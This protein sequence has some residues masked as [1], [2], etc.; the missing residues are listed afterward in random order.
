MRGLNLQ[1]VR[2]PGQENWRIFCAIE[3]PDNARERVIEHIGR[4][5]ESVRHAHASWSRPENIHLTLKFLGRLPKSGVGNLSQAA[6][7]SVEGFSIFKIHLEEAG[8]FPS[9]GAPRVLWIGVKDESGKL[10]ELQARLEDECARAGI[11][12]EKR[13][14][15]PHFTL[16]RLRES[17]GARNLASAHKQMRFQPFKLTV[18]E[19]L[20]IRSELNSDGSKYTLI[21]Q[22]PLGG[23]LSQI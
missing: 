12:R 16:A 21:S 13:P 17:P 15:H 3:L 9:R 2:A 6:Q 11:A 7:Q 19:L 22:H 8:A 4:L 1:D 23:G 14:F 18:S 10:F 20:V 5:R